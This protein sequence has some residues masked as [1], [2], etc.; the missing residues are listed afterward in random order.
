LAALVLGILVIAFAPMFG[1]VT[2]VAV[3]A[4]FAALLAGT[5]WYYSRSSGC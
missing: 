4:L 5:S 2:L 3:G 1:P